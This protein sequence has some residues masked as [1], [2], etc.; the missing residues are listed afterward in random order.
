MSTVFHTLDPW[1][2][3]QSSVLILG[4]MPSV[5]SREYGC[6]Y[7]HPQNRFWKTIASVLNTDIP[8]G[9]EEC[10]RYAL[11]H[12]LALWDILASCEMKGSEDASIRNEKPNDLT[13][14]LNVSPINRV[15]GLK[16]QTVI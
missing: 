4:T 1:F 16:I 9:S 11:E 6:Y 5:K 2:D 15:N 10:Y 13:R 7:G 3:S 12:H 14:I 8:V